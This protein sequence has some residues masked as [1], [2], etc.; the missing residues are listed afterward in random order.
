MFGTSVRL[1]A[2]LV[3]VL[4]SF[5]CDRRNPAQP[6][7]VPQT[8][9][10]TGEKYP[11][12]GSE[13]YSY[14]QTARL[15]LECGENC[16]L[17]WR[18]ATTDSLLPEGVVT[19]A[20]GWIWHYAAGADTS[21][22][23]SDP[24]CRRTIWTS[25][26]Q[27][28]WE[29]L[30]SQGRLP[31]I[32]SRVEVK[33]RR[34]DSP[35]SAYTAGFRDDR[36][37]S[38]L[39][40]VPFSAGETVGTGFHASL[41]EQVTDIYVEG[42]YA[43]HYMYRINRLDSGLNLIQS[44]PWLS[45]LDQED[46]RELSLTGLEPDLSDRFTQLEVYVVTRQGVQEATHKTVH[47][48][49]QGGFH[50]GTLIYPQLTSG[51]GQYHY[52]YS[53]E[54]YAPEFYYSN[55]N[56]HY[57][58]HLFGSSELYSAMNSPDFSL[59][60]SLG[61]KG[62]YGTILSNSIIITDD[63]Y[64]SLTN[65]CLDEDTEVNYFSRVTHFDLRL[66][67]A[68]FP[69]L[70]QYGPTSL[71]THADN[72]QW[73]RFRSRQD[74]ALNLMLGDLEDGTHSIQASAL[75]EQGVFDPSPAELTLQLAPFIPYSARS[76]IL[77]VDD[78]PHNATMCPDATVDAIYQNLLPET[79]GNIVQWDRA[80]NQVQDYEYREL[81]PL[82]LLQYKLVL[83]HSDNIGS[84]SNFFYELDPLA[85]YLDQGGRLIFGGGA[86]VK[87]T[88]QNTDISFHIWHDRFFGAGLS[89]QSNS[90][91][92]SA[93]ANPYFVAALSENAGWPDV[94]LEQE[95]SYLPFIA[96]RH[97]VGGISYFNEGTGLTQLFRFGCKLP[98]T[99]AYSP[100]QEV[101]EA[102]NTK[103]VALSRELAG[104]GKLAV[105]G[106]PLSLMEPAPMQQALAAII[107][108]MLPARAH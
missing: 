93:I 83:Y 58:T 3:L 1:S 50:P 104:G 77:I 60:L 85:V 67:G 54:K 28:S 59:R 4:L 22:P 33:V 63:P 106:F 30:S 69:A 97:G 42:L 76:G 19:D 39:I 37:I 86:N 66:D 96:S 6:D 64:H 48:R 49:V 35:E 65:Q 98:G 32:V 8:L 88:I 99:D 91:S 10:I 71:V 11:V 73:R 7:T 31:R 89:A 18:V 90:V 70:L 46:I 105:F 72:T 47:F 94:P 95:S 41:R 55:D 52:S 102:L 26:R 17:A 15:E 75:D 92:N 14:R 27:Q 53:N 78:D 84:G 21:I 101:Y 2:F 56:L 107:G 57:N 5:G 20:E 62:Q 43:H 108:T 81:S 24:A 80:D 16:R 9:Q 34:P 82:L 25:A 51:L 13:E 68:P 79:Y 12:P 61:W 87:S 100:T 40:I 36:V 45:S 44:G 103:Q 38:T 23:L 74:G 29:F